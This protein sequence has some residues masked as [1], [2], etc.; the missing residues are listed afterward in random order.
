[1]RRSTAD[2]IPEIAAFT[3]SRLSVSSLVRGFFRRVMALVPM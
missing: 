1:M 3:S 2:R